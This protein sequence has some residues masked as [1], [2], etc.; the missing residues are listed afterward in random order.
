[1]YLKMEFLQKVSQISIKIAYKDSFPLT[2]S[3]FLILNPEVINKVCFE[4][5]L[6][7]TISVA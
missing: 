3:V 5:L 4:I 1:M 2:V 7:L 6:Y